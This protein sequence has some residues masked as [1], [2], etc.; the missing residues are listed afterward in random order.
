MT[1]RQ[2]RLPKE[3]KA[4]GITEQRNRRREEKLCREPLNT[5]P[6]LQS[7]PGE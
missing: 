6:H 5:V 4:G 7:P 2:R 1:V 3:R